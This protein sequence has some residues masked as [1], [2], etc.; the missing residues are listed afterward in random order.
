M[1]RA[2]VGIDISASS[3]RA[4]E[5]VDLSKPRPRLVR[6]HEI[7]LAAGAVNRGEVVEPNT[8]ATAL[9]QLWS[10][11]GFK[12][13]DVVLGLGNS[14]VLARDLTVPRMSISQIRESLPFQVQ[15]MLPFPAEN[16]LLDFYP[17]SEGVGENGPVINGLLIAAIK[18]AVLSNVAAVQLAGLNPIDVDILPFAL[19]RVL[20]RGEQASGTTAIVDVGGSTTTVV[21]AT[22]GVPQ[23]V[24]I[25]PTG[26]DDLTAAIA[27]RLDITAE[28]AEGLKRSVGLRAGVIAPEDKLAVATIQEVTGELIASLRNTLSYFASARQTDVVSGVVLTGGGSLLSGFG[29]ALSESTRLPVTLG[30][31][32]ESVEMPRRLKGKSGHENGSSFAVAIGLAMGSA[33]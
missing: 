24:R 20:I 1:S 5:L 32:F 16:A 10:A 4:V 31:P 7:Q 9:K 13:K 23:F 33:A 8:V 18:E 25:I 17:I 28:L 2:I 21:I 19:I 30:D 14:R 12:T 15:D 29:E 26:G 11:G 22:D 27:A 3:I 6:H